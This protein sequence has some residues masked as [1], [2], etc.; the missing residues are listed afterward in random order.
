MKATD[1]VSIRLALIIVLIAPLTVLSV[2]LR[3]DTGSCSGQTITL[4]FTEASL[5]TGFSQPH[6]QTGGSGRCWQP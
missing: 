3:A 4:P 5:T 1:S 2:R 6:R